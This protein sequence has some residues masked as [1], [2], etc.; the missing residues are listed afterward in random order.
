LVEIGHGGA[1]ATNE[2]ATSRARRDSK[3]LKVIVAFEREFEFD[4]ICKGGGEVGTF[5]VIESRYV[6]R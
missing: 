1:V 5:I 4:K 3:I 6:E 2:P